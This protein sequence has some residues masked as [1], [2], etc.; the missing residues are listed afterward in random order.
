M[1]LILLLTNTALT[2]VTAYELTPASEF[3]DGKTTV[4]GTSVAV[5]HGGG[6]FQLVDLVNGK[7]GGFTAFCVVALLGNE[8]STESSHNTGNVRTNRLTACYT[9]KASKYTVVVEG[10]TLYHNMTSQLFGIGNLD[11]LVK[12]ILNNRVCKTCGNISYGCAF[13]LGL[14]YLG[15]HKYSTSCSKVNRVFCKKGSLGE[16]LYGVIQRL[17]EGFDKGTTARG[18]CLVQLYTV[19]SLITDFDTFHILSADI[20]DTVNLRVKESSRIVVGNG[21][22][23]PLIQQQR[24]LHQRLAVACGTG[25]RNVCILRKNAVDLLNGTDG[26]FK[27]ASVI[28]AVKGVKQSSVLTYKS[29]LSGGGTCINTQIAVA[30]ILGKVALLYLIGALTLIKC[31]IVFLCGKKRLHTF[32]LEIQFDG[33]LQAVCHIRKGNCYLI[34][35]IHGR[36]HGCEKMGILWCNGV[37]I[38]QLQGADKGCLQLIQKVKGT[39]EKCNMAA[40]RLAA[41]KTGNGLVY[42]CLENGSGKI[43]LGGTVVDQRLDVSLGKYTAAGCDGVKRFVILRV[44]VQPGGICLK[45][46]CHLIDERTGTSCADTIHTLFNIAAFEVDD[47]GILTAKLDGNISLGCNLL[48]RSGYRNYLLYKRNAKVVG[49]GKSAGACDYRMKGKLSKFAVGFRQKLCQCFLDVGEMTLVICEKQGV[50]FVKYCNF[51]SG[52]T[53][54]N[55]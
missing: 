51:D 2:A 11:N 21:L 25:K 46:G 8:G 6:I 28:I 39:A 42:N 37:F 5:G 29:G 3:V 31:L 34:L 40:N 22:N 23:F 30:V 52:G 33:V 12:R 43:L 7:H 15:V 13:L 48:K 53:N 38:I 44:F 1:I 16:I 17:G 19:Y 47:L 55:S 10:S 20:Y 54:V 49:E 18:T 24:G 45:Q 50:V 9:L 36:T 32:H 26:S 14:L 35:C 41:G 27:R 4:I